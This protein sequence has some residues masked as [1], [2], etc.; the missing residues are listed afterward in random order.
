MREQTLQQRLHHAVHIHGPIE[1]QCV[2]PAG[3]ND[4]VEAHQSGGGEQRCHPAYTTRRSALRLCAM[5]LALTRSRC[6]RREASNSMR[7]AQR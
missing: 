3:S 1:I 2:Q 4:P 6:R 5:I 7:P